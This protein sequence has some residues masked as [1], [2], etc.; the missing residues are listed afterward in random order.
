MAE[1]SSALVALRASVAAWFEARNLSVLV[2]LGWRG[3]NRDTGP[4]GGR[5]RIVFDVTEDGGRLLEA[6]AGARFDTRDAGAIVARRV[7]WVWEQAVTVILWAANVDHSDEE[8][9]QIEA[10]EALLEKFL[11]ALAGEESDENA[12]GDRRVRPGAIKRTVPTETGLGLEIRL[13]LTV[14]SPLYDEGD[15]I[16]FPGPVVNRGVLPP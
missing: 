9:A 1:Y 16:A 6:P 2:V 13:G 14:I 10:T 5:D 12:R 11:Q 15:A 4:G 7:L 3:K 8:D